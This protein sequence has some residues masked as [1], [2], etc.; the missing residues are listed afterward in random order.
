MRYPI[1]ERSFRVPGGQKAQHDENFDD[2][3]QKDAR[4]SSRQKH[5]T[6]FKGY[7]Q[8]HKIKHYTPRLKQKEAERKIDKYHSG[9]AK[10]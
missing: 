5:L 3:G 9:A 2:G 8:R 6:G 1:Y 10:K 7:K 4:V